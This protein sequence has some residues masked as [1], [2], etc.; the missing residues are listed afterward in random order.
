MF[1]KTLLDN[2][3]FFCCLQH[4]GTY[5]K[6]R[7]FKCTKGK[8]IFIQEKKIA[9]RWKPEERQIHIKNRSSKNVIERESKSK[10]PQGMIK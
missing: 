3:L 6:K 7:Y 4:D 8:G 10:K 5:R 9:N 2:F 1:Q